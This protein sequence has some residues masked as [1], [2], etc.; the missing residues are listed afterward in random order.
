MAKIKSFIT[1]AEVSVMTEPDIS[2]VSLVRHAANQQPFK[3]MKGQV[4]GEKSMNKVIHSILVPKDADESTL[5]ELESDYSFEEKDET[6]L[7]GFNIYKQVKDEEIDL[8]SKG[9]ALVDKEKGIY[10]IIANKTEKSEAKTIEK[11]AISWANKDSIFDSMFAMEDIIFGVLAQP[12]AEA[13]ERKAMI[14]SALANFGKHLEVVLSTMKSEDVVSIENIEVKGEFAE[15]LRAV[16]QEISEEA[17]EKKINDK[18]IEVLATVD[19]TVAKKTQAMIDN[20]IETS[21]KEM[22]EKLN[23]NLNAELEKMANKEAI[24]SEIETIKNEV[25][26]IKNTPK[27]RKSEIDEEVSSTKKSN[28]SKSNHNKYITFV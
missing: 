8:E 16:K 18:I 4:K 24:T 11:E 13:G 3:I 2:F 10:S 23:E 25:E 27:S 21:F 12:E 15:K 6:S 17:I 26:I 19:D 1:E 9:M 7:E 5:K 22:K 14:N 28:V 20:F